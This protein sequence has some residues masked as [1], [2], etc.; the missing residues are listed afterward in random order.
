MNFN[1]NTNTNSSKDENE[2]NLK[3]DNF[4]YHNSE[5]YSS[6]SSLTSKDKDKPT[7]N[8]TF[9]FI[10]NNNNNNNNNKIEEKTKVVY[11]EEKTTKLIL[12]ALY[13]SKTRWDNYTNSEGPTIAMGLDS[14]RKGMRNA[15]ERDVK[16]RYIAEITKHNINYCKELM[17]IAD[18]RHIDNAKGGMAVNE[19][20][21]IATAHLQEAKPV[22]HLIYSNVKEIVEQQQLVFESLWIN[23]IA[24]EQRIKEIEEGY[25]RIET[26]V[27]EN[28]E[29]IYSKIKSLTENSEEILVCSNIGLL[30]LVYNSLFDIYQKILDKYDRGYH[31]GIRWITSINCKE[32]VEVARLF[33]DIGI[34]IRNIKNLPP[35]NYLIS[36]KLFFSNIEN[37]NDFN[38]RKVFS[39]M[40]VSNDNL[41]VNHHRTIFEDLWKN[42]IDAIDVI[43]DVERGLDPERIEVISRSSNAEIVYLD[44][45]KSANNEIM[46]I[47]PTVNA[48]IRQHKIGVLNLI[49][50]AVINRNIKVRVLVPK[51]KN[52]IQL[53]EQIKN[54]SLSPN[55]NN[56][57]VNNIEF[58]YIHQLSGTQSTILIIDRKVSLVMELKDDTKDTFY[59]AIGLSTYSNSKA[60]VFSYISIFENLWKQTEL[61]QKLEKANERLKENER[62][63]KDFIHI[64]AHELRN[65]LQPILGSSEILKSIVNQKGSGNLEEKEVLVNKVKVNEILEIIVRNTKRILRL[66]SDVLDITKIETNS[67]ILHKEIVDLRLFLIDYLNDYKNQLKNNTEIEFIYPMKNNHD[68]KV[69]YTPSGNSFSKLNNIEN[70]DNGEIF[71]GEVD[72]SRIYQVISNLLDNAFKFINEN[73]TIYINIKKSTINKQQN[74]IIT[75]KDNG[76]G[77]DLDIMPR[78]F[79]KFT[80]KSEKGTGT[81]LGLFISKNIIEAH[82]GEIWGENNKDEKGAKF[83]FSLPLLT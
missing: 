19:T 46:L 12:K 64:A 4:N 2:N 69:K 72:K 74:A 68:N 9:N 59:E 77:I 47:F 79:T 75:I 67:F 14:L 60:G 58:R 73:G 78:L 62:L 37:F 36:D 38:E 24:A 45:L 21:Y 41:Y 25:E 31:R 6:S 48:Y 65:P 18:V 22:S 27:L 32:D 20:E 55:D 26:K 15:Y 17:K 33:M 34:K 54:K 23:A 7:K 29:D 56:N 5:E 83:S 80:T 49:T 66:T 82:G 28:W 76:R 1:T 81:G 8:E 43:D 42:G 63:Q 16:I 52:V 61:Y 70:E 40:L 3:K 57:N 30:K 71:T 11:G 10:N 50:D 44:L 51:N 35:L 13:N 53:I 39:N